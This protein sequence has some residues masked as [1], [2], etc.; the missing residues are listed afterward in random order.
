[1]I[2][3]DDEV[4]SSNS[5]GLNDATLCNWSATANR[6]SDDTEHGRSTTFNDELWVLVF[7]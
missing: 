4:H 3:W 5:S 6:W 7:M 1:M 2:Y